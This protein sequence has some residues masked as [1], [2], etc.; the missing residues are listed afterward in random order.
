MKGFVFVDAGVPNS[1]KKPEYRVKPALK[2]N[3]FA[4]AG[5]KRIM[6]KKQ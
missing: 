5:K 6:Q 3:K 2:F 4:K 1:K